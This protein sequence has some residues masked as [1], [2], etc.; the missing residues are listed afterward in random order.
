MVRQ[1]SMGELKCTA[2][3]QGWYAYRHSHMTTDLTADTNESA[4]ALERSAYFGGRNEACRIGK[5]PGKII[6]VDVS[7]MYTA[8]GITNEFPIRLTKIVWKPALRKLMLPNDNHQWI[9]DVTVSVARPFLPVRHEG[10][11]LYPVGEFRTTLAYPELCLA[12]WEGAIQRVHVAAEYETANIFS[13]WAS[14]YQHSLDR[15]ELLGLAHM[16]QALKLA[17]NSTYGKIGYRGREWVDHRYTIPVYD[18]GQWWQR[19]PTNRNVVQWRS[20]QNRAQ[21][22]DAG[23]EPQRSMPFISA[24]MNSYGR[25]HLWRLLQIARPKNVFYY[26]TDGIMVNE[27][28]YDL[29]AFAKEVQPGEIGKLRIREVSDDVEIFGLKHYRFGKRYCCA[30]VPLESMVVKPDRVE[31]EQHTPFV[32]SLW[33]KKGFIHHYDKRTRTHKPKVRHGHLEPTGSVLPFIMGEFQHDR[34][35]GTGN[36]KAERT[37][38]ILGSIDP[39]SW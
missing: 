12:A 8:F 36:A 21:Y 11:I 28:G 33:Q 17:V 10:R 19:H 13:C 29:L 2:A 35:N 39:S 37:F 4:R 30:G 1:L 22:L 3:T 24:T 18:F 6:H 27:D 7:A 20:I 38:G 16:R 14:W 26:D 34:D 15:L 25:V 23:S 32:Y 9:A 31:F 5:L